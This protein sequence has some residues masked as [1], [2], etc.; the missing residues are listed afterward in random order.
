MNYA[1]LKNVK[2]KIMYTEAYLEPSQR[3]MMEL[4]CKNS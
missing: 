4:F 2:C 1:L 3:P